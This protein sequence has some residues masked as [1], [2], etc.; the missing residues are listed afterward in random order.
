M[1][2]YLHGEGCCTI[3]LEVVDASLSRNA[4]ANFLDMS[5]QSDGKLAS[6]TAPNGLAQER[7]I[8]QALKVSN[9]KPDD[10][11]YIEAHGTGTALGDPI[12]IEALAGVFAASISNSNSLYPLMVGSVKSNIGHLEVAAGMAGLINAILVLCQESVPPNVGLEKLN[13]CIKE[14]VASHGFLV[15]FPTVLSLLR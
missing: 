2:G 13:P 15:D 4:Y 11:D 10:V 12:E 14:S 6:I 1:D 7:L 5:F 9:I 3:I 8:R